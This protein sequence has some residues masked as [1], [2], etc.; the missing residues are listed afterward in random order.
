MT[1]VPS[2]PILLIPGTWGYAGDLGH[3][4]AEWWWPGDESGHKPSPWVARARSLGFRI[5]A[6]AGAPFVWSSDLGASI[7]PLPLRHWLR[8]GAALPV[9]KAAAEAARDYCLVAGIS[10]VQ[11][12][13]HSHGGQVGAYLAA[14]AP[15]HL[16]LDVIE[17]VTLATPAREDMAPIYKRARANVAHWD[18]IHGGDRDWWQLFG[19]VCD[20]R[21]GWRRPMTWATRNIAVPDANHQELTTVDVWD[22]CGLWRTLR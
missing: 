10:R 8:A 19:E 6:R 7:I 9:Y 14:M 12:V 13:A 20:G 1:V 21:F 11:V 2:D 16:G 17:L 15:R 5:L 18:H 3:D 4:T 22:R